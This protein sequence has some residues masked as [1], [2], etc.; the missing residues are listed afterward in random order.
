MTTR[1]AFLA[2]A[3]AAAFVRRGNAVGPAD[4]SPTPQGVD[5]AVEALAEAEKVLGFALTPEERKQALRVVV[6]N[7]DAARLRPTPPLGMDD[8]PATVFRPTPPASPRRGAD[9]GVADARPSTDGGAFATEGDLAFASLPRLAASLAAGSTTSVALTELALS[10]LKAHD[11][12][13]RCVVSL[14]ED[15][16]RAEAR[17]S[18]AE[19]AAGRVRGPLHG[20]PYGLKDLFDTADA[21]TT[22]GVAP[23]KD[24]R[25]TRDAAVVERLRAAG[26]VLVAKLSLGELA[27][28]DVWFGGRTNSPWNPDDGSSGSSAGSCSAVAAGLVPFAIGTE[29]LGS[30]VSPSM[31]CGTTG[32]R[33]TFGAVSLRG[34]M[35]LCWSLDKAGP[36]ARSSEDAWLVYR[37]IADPEALAAAGARERLGTD[38][39]GLKVGHVPSYFEGRSE[40]RELERRA[41]EALRAAGAELIAVEAPNFPYA[42]LRT[43]LNVEAAAAMEEWTLSG[44]DD[45][46]AQQDASSWPNLFRAA[47]YASAV[48]FVQADRLRRRV[49]D[50]YDR[51]FEPLDVLIGPSFSGPFLLAT[52]FTGHPCLVVRV[53]FPTRRGRGAASGPVAVPHGISLWAKTYD[54]A[55]LV[56]AGSALEAALGVADR[57]PPE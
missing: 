42:A 18:D 54:E 38:V 43:I 27:M 19:R 11:P 10:R 13:L 1:R 21:P 2:A 36:I 9:F 12:R 46:L 14:R 35:P 4:A 39:R 3:A 55:A 5:L 17:A 32:L 34:A 22:W 57:R 45:L 24:R 30:I 41:L 16:A 51:L 47:R 6:E 23:Q 37:A 40:A 28:G 7:R 15:A 53:G 49:A 56:R 33:P 25:P 52:N 29:T 8:A 26:A 48:D 20:I 31:R 50:A 44:R